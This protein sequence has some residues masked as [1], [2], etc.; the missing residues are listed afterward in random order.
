MAAAGRA[1]PGARL[2]GRMGCADPVVR[3]PIPDSS[4]EDSHPADCNRIKPRHG[5]AHPACRNPTQESSM[6]VPLSSAMAWFGPDLLG[7]SLFAWPV[8]APAMRSPGTHGRYDHAFR[9]SCIYRPRTG[10]VPATYPTND[11]IWQ[12][13]RTSLP[14]GI[15]AAHSPLAAGPRRERHAWHPGMKYRCCRQLSPGWIPGHP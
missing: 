15:H 1:K 8:P 12:A 5:S 14:E 11:S 10:R 2:P 6:V 3:L 7:R 13:R 9:R 4:T